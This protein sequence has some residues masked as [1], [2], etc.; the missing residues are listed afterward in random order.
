[1][2]WIT[3]ESVLGAGIWRVDLHIGIYVTR[4]RR[5]YHSAMS[6]KRAA[7]RLSVKTGWPIVED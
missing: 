2:K 7:K 5:S 6:A 4:S 3:V 1:M